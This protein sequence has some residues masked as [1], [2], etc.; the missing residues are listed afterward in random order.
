[1]KELSDKMLRLTLVK[2]SAQLQRP[3][4]APGNLLVRAHALYH[5]IRYGDKPEINV[6]VEP[7]DR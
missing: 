1:M 4:D 7:S 5:W 6:P 3:N 2:I